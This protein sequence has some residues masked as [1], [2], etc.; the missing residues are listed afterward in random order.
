MVTADAAGR[1]GT[2][3]IRG[4]VEWLV[5]QEVCLPGEAA[6][7]ME[8]PLAGAGTGA[9]GELSGDAARFVSARERLPLVDQRLEAWGVR[10]SWLP[11]GE[12]RGPVLAFHAAEATGLRWYPDEQSLALLPL[13]RYRESSAR[14]DSAGDGVRIGVTY[15]PTVVEAGWVRGVLEIE[16]GGSKVWL[17]VR[18]P[19]P[20]ASAAAESSNGAGA[21]DGESRGPIR[22]RPQRR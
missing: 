19:P 5:C 6:V 17:D 7:S 20:D 22:P 15:R 18:L 4:E 8:L 16:R 11:R 13:N 9:E 3:A 10:S 2:V 1:G 21:G 14:S 12:G